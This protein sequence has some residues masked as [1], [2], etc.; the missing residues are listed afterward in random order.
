MLPQVTELNAWAASNDVQEGEYPL[1]MQIYFRV[2]DSIT[3]SRIPAGGLLKESAFARHFGVSREPVRRAFEM[4]READLI[5]PVAGQGYM[6]R[7]DSAEKQQLDAGLLESVQSL[8]GA[9][10]LRPAPKWRQIY[11]RVLRDLIRQAVHGGCP[12][13]P[14]QLADYYSVSRT[15]AKELLSALMANGLVEQDNQQKWFLEHFSENLIRDMNEV[16]RQL[17]PHA[18]RRAFGSLP[19]LLVDQ[20]ISRHRHVATRLPE[21]YA[22]TF[23]ELEQGLHESLLSHCGNNVLMAALRKS[24]IVR[25]FNDHYYDLHR[26]EDSCVYEHLVVLEAIKAGDQEAAIA[27]L[28][29]HI[30]RSTENTINRLRHFRANH[31]PEGLPVFAR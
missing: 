30:N 7:G 6:V 11:P 15:V 1:Y 12:I 29:Y 9:G 20:L 21:V 31:E 10:V 13:V 23:F 25:S 24:A 19:S 4:L 5:A 17:E 3:S 16:R 8:D 14:A 28:D 2:L 26:P 22:S 27:A 18:L